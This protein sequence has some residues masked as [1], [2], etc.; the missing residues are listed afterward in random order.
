[1]GPPL[2]ESPGRCQVHER[3]RRAAEPIKA[4]TTTRRAAHEWRPVLER[5]ARRCA[6][7]QVPARLGSGC[8]ARQE[9]PARWPV[10]CSV[11]LCEG[12]PT[13]ATSGVTASLAQ[14]QASKGR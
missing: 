10:G 14:G 1:M 6:R 2:T 11:Q 3:G 4:S 12:E 7:H 5:M 13:S 9:R 8:S